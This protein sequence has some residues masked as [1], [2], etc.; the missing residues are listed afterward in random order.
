MGGEGMQTDEVPPQLM[1]QALNDQALANQAIISMGSFGKDG[2]RLLIDT[3]NA[4]PQAQV[5]AAAAKGPGQIG[6]ILRDGS[7]VPA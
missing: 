1:K 6:G 5:Q 2:T 7:V 4:P 3:R